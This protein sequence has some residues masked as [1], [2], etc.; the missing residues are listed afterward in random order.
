MARY[1]CP[2]CG[3]PYNGRKCRVCCYEHFSE[4]ITHGNHTHKG[5]PLVIDTPVRRPIPKKDPFGC[6]KKPRKREKKGNP[7]V[8][9]FTLLYIIYALLPMVRNWGLE[10]ERREQAAPEPVPAVLVAI[11]EEDGIT[12]SVPADQLSSP[13]WEKGLQI[14]VENRREEDLTVGTRYVTVNG[15]ALP[16]ASLHVQANSKKSGMGTL[17]LP[18]ADLKDANIRSIRELTFVLEGMDEDYFDVFVT[19]PITMTN[20][21]AATSSTSFEG[22]ILLEEE[23][24]VLMDLGNWPDPGFSF[25]QGHRLFYVEN[26]TDEFLFM[27]SL[28]IRV[29]EKIVDLF[30][31][32]GIPA[33]SRAVVRMELL[34]LEALD[35]TTPSELEDLHMT[36]E[37]RS[38]E[39]DSGSV[40]EYVLT[41]PMTLTEPVVIS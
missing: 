40:R 7:L 10:L 19:D 4:E 11:H 14:W 21:T 12:I 38:P 15:F 18:E 30:L 24:L 28:E 26:N 33:H 8:R 37:F 9:F 5:E 34:G 6:E 3:A 20:E 31:W 22:R 41:T 13:H 32:A 1:T 16:N 39:N 2:G 27:N 25:E 29:G 36:V 35:V 23:G 17:Y